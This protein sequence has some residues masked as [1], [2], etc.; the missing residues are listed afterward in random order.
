MLRFI[1]TL[2]AVASVASTALAE[3]SSKGHEVALPVRQDQMLRE[4]IGQLQLDALVS[5]TETATVVRHPVRAKTTQDRQ[6]EHELAL[7]SY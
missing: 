2:A 4:R 5:R 6:L 3:I 1:I 7:Y